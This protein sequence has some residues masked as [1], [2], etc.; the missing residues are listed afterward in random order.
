MF[1]VKVAIKPDF[2]MFGYLMSGCRH[3]FRHLLMQLSVEL[4]H[5]NCAS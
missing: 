1:C 4:P 3:S 2:K 5:V